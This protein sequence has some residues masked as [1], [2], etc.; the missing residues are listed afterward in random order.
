M[1]PLNAGQWLV[2]L[3]IGLT[4]LL[5]S[6]GDKVLRAWLLAHGHGPRSGLWA[7]VHHARRNVASM[8]NTSR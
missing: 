3:L 7:I 2:C 6:E 1:V 5:L 8:L 4:V